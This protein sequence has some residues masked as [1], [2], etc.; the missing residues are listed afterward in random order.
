VLNL[1]PTEDEM[2]NELTKST[3]H[4]SRQIVKEFGDGNYSGFACNLYVYKLHYLKVI[5]IALLLIILLSVTKHALGIH[6]N[7]C[8]KY[9]ISL[10]M[11]SKQDIT[12]FLLHC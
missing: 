12:F 10:T 6:A 4:S 8:H 2:S 7:F 5:C 11:D 1:F 3:L 9:A